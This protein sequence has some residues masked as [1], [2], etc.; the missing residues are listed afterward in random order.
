MT[1]LNSDNLNLKYEDGIAYMTVSGQVSKEEM[2]EGLGWFSEVLDSNDNFNMCVDMAQG[3]FDGLGEVRQGFTR[4]ADVLRAVPSVDKCAVLT[5]SMFLRNSAK[6]EGAVIP[7]L[8]IEAYKIEEIA[9]AV[10]WLKDEDTPEALQESRPGVADIVTDSATES[11]T[12]VEAAPLKTQ[13]LVNEL[14]ETP[15]DNPW[16]NLKL[17]KVDY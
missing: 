1:A 6:V 4:V 12:E 7:G 13:P 9:P 10:S 15:S 2:A 17:A 11:V 8:E 3:D 5:D 14:V 16:D